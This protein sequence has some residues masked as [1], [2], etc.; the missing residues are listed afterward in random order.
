M[1]GPSRYSPE[2]RERA[3]RL[4]LEH[5][6]ENDSLVERARQNASEQVAKLR[7]GQSAQRPSALRTHHW[8]RLSQIDDAKRPAMNGM[9]RG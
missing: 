7:V 4:V 9:W 2:V 6:A 8:A 3:V 5:Q 1:G